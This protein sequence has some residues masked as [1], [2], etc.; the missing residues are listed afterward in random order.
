M[1]S[2][3]TIKTI[4]VT[5]KGDMPLI[6]HN[7]TLCDP[8][9]PL[10]VELS[11]ITVIR[12]KQLEHHIAMARLEFE[13]GLYYSENYG[14]HIPSKLIFGCLKSAA[15]KFKLGVAMKSLILNDIAFPLKGYKKQTPESLWNAKNEAG[16]SKYVFRESVNVN[17]SKIMRTRPMFQEWGFTFSGD[18]D[19]ELISTEQFEKILENAGMYCGLGDLRPEKA[20]GSFGKFS[21][22][23]FKVNG[24]EHGKRD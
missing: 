24:V 10:T 6:M 1:E 19:I 13:G 14:L 8:L 3:E 2:I 9:N 21:I 17:R 4:E 22:E 11:K 23:S 15:R 7:D 12:K 18:L 5:I 16:T 20:S